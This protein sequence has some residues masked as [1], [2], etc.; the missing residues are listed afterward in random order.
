MTGSKSYSIQ[1]VVSGRR[2]KP[3]LAEVQSRQ[4]KV[5]VLL[6]PLLDSLVIALV[7]LT[8]CLQP[9]FVYVLEE[10]LLALF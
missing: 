8:C 2:H 10:P 7:S 5:L 6:E 3:H 4:K 9:L 1:T